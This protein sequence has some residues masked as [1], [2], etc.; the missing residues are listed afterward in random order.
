MVDTAVYAMLEAFVVDIGYVMVEALA[1]VSVKVVVVEII[2]M[3]VVRVKV[4]VAEVVTVMVE[5]AMNV[6]VETIVMDSVIYLL[7]TP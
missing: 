1:E 4:A 2:V 6:M 5:V 7:C 3:E